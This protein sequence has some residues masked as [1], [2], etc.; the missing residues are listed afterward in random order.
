MAS[1][2][3]TDFPNDY[4]PEAKW[5][6]EIQPLQDALVGS[7]RP[8]LLVLMAAVVLVV[9]IASVNI[10]NVLLARALGRQI[11]IAMLMTLGAARFR[12][13][14]QLL[15]DALVLSLIAG[16]AGVLRA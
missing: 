11:V 1:E 10:A 6:I 7:V 4:S 2:L 13:V 3:R 5:S 15:T 9:L 16:V 8:Q 14:R 12:L